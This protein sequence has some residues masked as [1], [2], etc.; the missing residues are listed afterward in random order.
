MQPNP[1]PLS[2]TP[3][4][5]ARL[6]EYSDLVRA[7]APALDLFG[8]AV[9]RNW[10]EHLQSAAAYAAAVPPGTA[11]VLDLGSGGGLP[12]VVVS[13]L[14]PEARVVLCERRL[15][16]ATFLKTCVARLGLN[17]EVL[18]RDVREYPPALGAPEVVTAQAVAGVP[19]LLRLLDGVVPE[20]FTLLSRRGRDWE[21]PALPGWAGNAETSDLA[22]LPGALLWPEG[23]Q[24]VR[25][26]LWRESTGRAASRRAEE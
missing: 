8:P 16:R 20:A 4:Q 12:G 17:A 1:A 18:A 11:R 14:R 6:A 24:L 2:P 10:E 3:E 26:R 22:P 25:L 23:H 21:L 9:L 19:E 13:V 5:A 15:K 7:Y